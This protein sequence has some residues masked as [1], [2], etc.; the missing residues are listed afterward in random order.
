[1]L[2]IFIM[3]VH[4]PSDQVLGMRA[5]Q[6]VWALAVLPGLAVAYLVVVGIRILFRIVG[7]RGAK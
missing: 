1:L 7:R 3:N 4:G 6:L 2:I 5:E